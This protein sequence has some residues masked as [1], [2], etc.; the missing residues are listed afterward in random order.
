MKLLIYCDSKSIF[1]YIPP[2]HRIVIALCIEELSR[3]ETAVGIDHF[4]TKPTMVA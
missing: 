4:C 3:N 1:C 2:W